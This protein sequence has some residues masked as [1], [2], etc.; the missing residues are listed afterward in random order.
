MAVVAARRRRR[1][2]ARVRRAWPV[3]TAA[4]VAVVTV[5]APLILPAFGLTMI[6]IGVWAWSTPAGMVTLGVSVLVLDN[7]GAIIQRML[8]NGPEGRGT[9]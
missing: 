5:L 2:S 1:A 3:V 8:G 9:P 4:A 7:W 6:T